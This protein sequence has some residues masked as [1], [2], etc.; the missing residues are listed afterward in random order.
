MKLGPRAQLLLIASLFVLPIVAST[1]AYRFGHRAPT[2]NHGELLLPPAQVNDQSFGR[3]GGGAFSFRELRGR[4]ALVAIDSGACAEACRAKLTVMRQ[5]RLALG[6]NASRVA[7]VLF[8]DDQQPPDM[9]ALAPFEG[10]EVA[11][12]PRGA[13]IAPPAAGDRSRLYL[14]DP[15]GNVM[16]RWAARADPEGMIKDLERLL[17]ASQIG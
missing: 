13:A 11:V 3:P 8:V 2:A 7:R 9:A 17:K 15:H 12:A 4:W 6:R 10:T 5:V 1:L 16:M 14:V